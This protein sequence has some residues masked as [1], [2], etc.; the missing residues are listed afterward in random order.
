[1]RLLHLPALR[2]GEP[3]RRWHQLAAAPAGYCSVPCRTWGS[4]GSAAPLGPSTCTFSPHHPTPTPPDPVPEE[5]AHPLPSCC[6]RLRLSTFW[7]PSR[8]A[9]AT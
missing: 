3:W 8:P 9:T 6:S 2:A 1:V 5:M 7:P 4:V